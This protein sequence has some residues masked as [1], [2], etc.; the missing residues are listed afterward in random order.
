MNNVLSIFGLITVDSRPVFLANEKFY[1][2]AF[3][4]VVRKITKIEPSPVAMKEGDSFVIQYEV[5]SRVQLEGFVKRSIK[6]VFGKTSA[7]SELL[8]KLLGE[9]QDLECSYLND[10]NV[11]SSRSKYSYLK[12]YGV[13]IPLE[14]ATSKNKD[15]HKYTEINIQN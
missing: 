1:K 9:R 6:C 7:A 3:E 15:M 2:S 10:G 4:V 13:P 8:P 12:N 11:A 5:G 14:T